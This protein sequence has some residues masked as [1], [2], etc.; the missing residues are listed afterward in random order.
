MPWAF[1]TCGTQDRDGHGCPKGPFRQ[2]WGL[3]RCDIAIY[4]KRYLVFVPFA[5]TKLLKPLEFPV[6]RTERCFVI[7]ME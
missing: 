6:M 5:G 7:L 4:D 2:K 3:G 1:L